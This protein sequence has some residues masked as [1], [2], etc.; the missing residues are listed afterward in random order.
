MSNKKAISVARR[1]KDEFFEKLEN[2]YVSKINPIK[3]EITK[4]KKENP[5]I[6]Y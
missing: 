2:W 6:K 1:R 5:L 4:L 3:I